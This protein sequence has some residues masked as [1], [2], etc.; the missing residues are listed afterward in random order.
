MRYAILALLAPFVLV[1]CD[2]TEPLKSRPATAA[3]PARPATTLACAAPFERT[4]TAASL[5]HAFGGANVAEESVPG[6]E[7]AQINA[8][9]IYSADAARRIQVLWADE[10]ARAGLLSAST[11]QGAPD[12]VPAVVG[13]LG[14]KVGATVE[15]VEAI[16]GGPFA[17]TGFDWD[18]GGA[19]MDWQGGRLGREACHVTV[20]FTPSADTYSSVTG[21][22]QF[23]SNSSSMR[24]ARPR[25]ARIGIGY[26]AP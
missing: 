7:G 9:V 20:Q 5:A 1:A 19:V 3:A 21:D 8:T 4:A 6:P 18:Y 25:V 22:T 12:V 16:N 24:A 23:P 26:P 11:E 15:E 17:L 14:L 2:R 10:T 13:P